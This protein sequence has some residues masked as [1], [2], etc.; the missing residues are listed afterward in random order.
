MV[1]RQFYDLMFRRREPISVAFD[2]L[3]H[4]VPDVRAWPLWRRKVWLRRLVPADASSI[5]FADSVQG[6][7]VALFAE[8]VRRDLEGIVAKHV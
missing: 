2:L 1:P 5:L 3:A 6:A 7:G 4:G 8:A